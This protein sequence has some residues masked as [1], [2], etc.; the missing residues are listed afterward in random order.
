MSDHLEHLLVQLQIAR[1]DRK[2]LMTR[3]AQSDV[4]IG[5]LLLQIEQAIRPVRPESVGAVATPAVPV[6]DPGLTTP[7]ETRGV[8]FTLQA[9]SPRGKAALPEIEALLAPLLGK[10][11]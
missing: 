11:H 5:E 7:C 8:F 9:I 10:S 1:D 2:L 6:G 3:V 4:R